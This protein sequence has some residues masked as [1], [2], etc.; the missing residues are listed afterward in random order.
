VAV[1]N[2][3]GI[4][5]AGFA[6]EADAILDD[7][8][9][10]TGGGDVRFQRVS[11]GHAGGFTVYLASPAPSGAIF[12]QGGLDPDEFTNCRLS[13][14]KVVINSARWLTAVPGYGAP[15]SVYR[16]Y[17]INH[18]VG[19]QLGYQHELCPGP[20]RPAPVMQQQTLGLHGCVANAWPYV[21]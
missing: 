6:A 4:D 16:G 11:S 13:P 9:S 10:W 8:R 19:H 18:E 5:V 15:L 20:G 17:A 7:P 12:A 1:E 21:N 2:G 14:G 3:I